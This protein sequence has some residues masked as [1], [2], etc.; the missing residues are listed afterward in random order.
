VNGDLE[1]ARTLLQAQGKALV[2]V[3]DGRVLGTGEHKGMADLLALAEQLGQEAQGAALADRVVGKAA[4]MVARSMGVASVY[5]LLVS[6]PAREALAKGG[7]PLEYEQLVPAILNEKGAGPC[8]LERLVAAIEDPAEAERV[9]RNFLHQGVLPERAFCGTISSGR[10][11]ADRVV[12]YC[13]SGDDH[14]DH[15]SRPE[16]PATGDLFVWRR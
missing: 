12:R 10:H 6:Q 14:E 8:P 15:P 9:L 5:A 7:V 2:L 4:A 1:L 3:K 11:E 16:G 13:L